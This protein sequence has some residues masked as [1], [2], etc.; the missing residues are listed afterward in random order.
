MKYKSLYI[1]AFILV[2]FVGGL[3]A[4]NNALYFD[5]VNDCV[6]IS[7][8][9]AAPI[10]NAFTVEA[11]FNTKSTTLIPG[12]V[13]TYG[14][15]I[16]ASSKE[17]LPQALT[18]IWVS[19]RGTELWV[20]ASG[21][22]V[23][24]IKTVGLNL[25][26]DTWYHVAVSVGADK[27]VKLY[28]N[29]VYLQSGVTA[30]P[31]LNWEFQFTIGDLRPDKKIPFW[32]TIDEVRVWNYVRTPAEIGA[33][34]DKTGLAPTAGLVGNWKLD[35]STGSTAYD[36]VSPAHNGTTQNGT[37][38]NPTPPWVPGK[39][40]DDISLPVELSSFT[41]VLTAGN[42]V[43]V[44][45]VTES[46]TAL[47]GYRMYRNDTFDQATALS[48]TP[49]M[50]GATNTST[51]Q[52]YS[53]TD[54]EVLTGSTYYYWLESIDMDHTTFHGP[55]S[56]NYESTVAPVLPEQTN[57]NNAYPNPFKVNNS[58]NIEVTV[59]AG[60]KGNVTIYNILGQVVKDFPVNEGINSLNW[61]GNDSKG[62]ACSNGIYFYKL[63]TPSMNITKKMIIVK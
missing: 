60:E 39:T 25:Q 28:V 61:N 51:T 27:V 3:F 37:V 9:R 35:E 43:T 12:N 8:L 2:C 53:I 15:T 58:T 38:V 22:I 54:T 34:Y 59:K 14:R 40:L 33:N 57:M 42:Y 23:T 44:K 46:E 20:F 24:S 21:A 47:L 48:I 62:N 31:A 63:A 18:P 41:A 6:S 11:W 55:V 16:I 45:W 5:G 13:T 30:N 49:I 17:N 52:T 50:I 26:V 4:Q 19:Q 32:G 1:I 10:T 7:D 56:V 29:G 36:S